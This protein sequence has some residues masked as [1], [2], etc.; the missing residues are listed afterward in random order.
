V[1]LLTSQVKVFNNPCAVKGAAFLEFNGHASHVTNCRFTHG[2]TDLV[3]CGGNDRCILQWRVSSDNSDADTVV[4]AGASP[5]RLVGSTATS[6]GGVSGGHG[7]R[8]ATD[9]L[10]LN[11]SAGASAFGGDE[12]MAVKPWLGA[13]VAP[14]MLNAGSSGD[15]AGA[16]LSEMLTA[17][18]DAFN[19]CT[20]SSAG[21]DTAGGRA[22]SE[23][24]V[25][26]QEQVRR[27]VHGQL[28]GAD[29]GPPLNDDLELEWYVTVCERK[30]R[31]YEC[32]CA[33]SKYTLRQCAPR[34]RILFLQPLPLL[35]KLLT[36]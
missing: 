25:L 15:A 8:A 34:S 5:K 20:G 3:S 33:S 19:R 16:P 1:L 14:S 4:G 7:P 11:S 26:M 23:E 36:R 30:H 21:T 17:Y 13:I 10:L 2:D 24:L 29:A 32:L 9:S 22:V 35:L 27:R 31:N 28:R 18:A 12:F 6:S